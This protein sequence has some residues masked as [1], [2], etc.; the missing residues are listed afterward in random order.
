MSVIEKTYT[1]EDLWELSRGG[2]RLELIEGELVEMSPA[3]DT[4]TELV[5]W[6]NYL[7]FEHVHKNG[8]GAVSSA[9]GGYTLP[10]E[11]PTVLAPDVGFI[12]QARRT[13][14]TGKF[15]TVAPDLAV[16]VVSPTDAAREI[17]KKVNL[18]LKAGTRLVW[19]LY[20]DDRLIDVYTPEERPLTLQGQDVLD[21]GAVLPGF[22]MTVAEVF[23]QLDA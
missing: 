4:H 11:P 23:R 17:R 14:R 2:V 7:I 12:S 21:G 5:S 1:A 13:P 19:V 10:I 6:L 9:D 3:G 22:A 8:L 15:Y 16:E 18:Y 20:P